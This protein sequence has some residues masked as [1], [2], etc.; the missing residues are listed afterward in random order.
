MIETSL[1]WPSASLTISTLSAT[2][3][4]SILTLFS[5]ACGRVIERTI[6]SSFFLYSAKYRSDV[7]MSYLISE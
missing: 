5:T 7:F 4:T 3:S 6:C 2:E 1:I